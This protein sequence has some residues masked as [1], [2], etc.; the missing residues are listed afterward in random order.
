M[1]KTRTQCLVFVNEDVESPEWINQVQHF[2]NIIILGAFKTSPEKVHQGF[3]F[4]W[5]TNPSTKVN[6]SD[7]NQRTSNLGKRKA[8]KKSLSWYLSKLFDERSLFGLHNNFRPVL[9]NICGSFHKKAF[10]ISFCLSTQVTFIK[11]TKKNFCKTF[12]LFFFAPLLPLVAL[13]SSC[14]KQKYFNWN[15]ANIFLN[16]IWFISGAS[17]MTLTLKNY[18]INFPS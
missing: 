13:L 14:F 16:N 17:H 2:P 5:F 8:S 6:A 11:E 15:C 3:Q 4:I 7:I 9:C 18:L 10:F 1:L 12:F